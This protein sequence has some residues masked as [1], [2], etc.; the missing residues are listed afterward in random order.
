VQVHQGL[1][2]GDVPGCAQGDVDDEDG[3]DGD[4]EAVAEDIDRGGGEGGREC[5]GGCG[6]QQVM[7]VKL[8]CGMRIP[9]EDEAGGCR[10]DTEEKQI[11]N[12]VA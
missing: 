7:Q 3:G 10:G 1:Q 2:G 9:A 5:A 8:E 12:R 11:A 4:W 6:G